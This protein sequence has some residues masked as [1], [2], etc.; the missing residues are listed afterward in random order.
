MRVHV[1]SSNPVKL[2]A[3]RRVFT[4]AFLDEI[5]DVVLVPVE[6]GV[7]SQPLGD[8]VARGAVARA[9]AALQGADYGVG[10]EAGLIYHHALKL[11]FDVQ[12]CAIVDRAGRVTVGHGPG[13]VYPRRVLQAVLEEG[14]TVGQAMEALTG[15]EHI[16]HKMGAIGFLSQGLMDRRALTEQA[17]LMALLPRLRPDLYQGDGFPLPR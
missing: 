15:I 8:E 17:V 1:G 6:P 7:P 3:V 11:H 2:E 13:F 16:G 9:R 12:F 10:I 14:Q 4:R 5:I